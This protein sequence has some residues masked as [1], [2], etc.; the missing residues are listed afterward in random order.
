MNI[1][2]EFEF[3]LADGSEVIVSSD[4]EVYRDEQGDAWVEGLEVGFA[5]KDTRRYMDALQC[6]QNQMGEIKS[7]IEDRLVESHDE[8][9]SEFKRG[10]S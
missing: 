6:L 5:I 7:R 8:N 9:L 10:A 4:A 3:K 2:D 1:T